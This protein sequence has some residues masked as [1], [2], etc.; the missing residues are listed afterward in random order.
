VDVAVIQAGR[1]ESMEGGDPPAPLVDIV[2]RGVRLLVDKDGRLR[3]LLDRPLPPA[4]P[5]VAPSEGEFVNLTS[6]FW[7]HALW[8]TRHL[9]RGE[10]WWAKGA[11]DGLLKQLLGRMLEWHAHATHAEVV[12]TWLRGRFLEEWADPRAVAELG[13]AFAHYDAADMAR[14]LRSTM[15]L[16]RWVEDETASL[17]SFHPPVHGEHAAANLATR[18]LDEMMARG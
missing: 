14:A 6:N 9:R 5:A 10:L 12:D 15:A 4:P 11:V 2:R 17:L 18:L 7:Y 8:S 1:L 16:F 13:A 3:S